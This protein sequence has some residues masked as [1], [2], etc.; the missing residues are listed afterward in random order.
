LSPLA[1]SAFSVAAV[2]AV[3][4][5]IGVTAG[6]RP[7]EYVGKPLTML[8]LAIGA[9]LLRPVAEPVHWMIVIGLLLGGLGDVLLMTG[10]GVSTRALAPF[11][12]GHL[13]YI[14]A[15][16]AQR[17]NLPVLVA[18]GLVCLAAILVY[19][20]WLL[21]GLRASGRERLVRPVLVYMIVIGAMTATA[22]GTLNPLA[23]AGALLFFGSDGLFAWYHFVG[24]LRWGRPANI[25]LYQ[26]G[27][28]LIA[29]SLMLAS[30]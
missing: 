17:Q 10:G 28:G 9:A 7:L 1:V 12:A 29:A 30:T 21:A 20:R 14:L 23:A 18:A 11:L 6:R 15:F 19:Q 4:T 5:W 25:V 3:I 24:P 13:A 26:C 16:T 27:Q 2:F 22:C 8:L